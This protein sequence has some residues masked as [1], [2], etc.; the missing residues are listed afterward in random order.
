MIR[1]AASALLASA[2]PP[3]PEHAWNCDFTTKY[4]CTAEGCD[5]VTPTISITMGPEFDFY[6]RCDANG[7]D[8]RRAR[9]S[10]SGEFLIAEVTGSGAFAKVSPDLAI[11]E[12]VSLGHEVFVSYGTCRPGPPS[13]IHVPIPENPN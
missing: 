13:L 12:V 2:A 9:Y 11:T 7:C 6:S 4:R 10:V 3:S 8:T 1:F 5:P